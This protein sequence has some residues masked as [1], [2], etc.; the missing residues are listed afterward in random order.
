MRKL[1]LVALLFSSACVQPAPDPGPDA[2]VLG[3]KPGY[4]TDPRPGPGEADAGAD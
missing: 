1:I 2:T 3:E 4:D